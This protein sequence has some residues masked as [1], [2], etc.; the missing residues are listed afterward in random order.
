MRDSISNKVREYVLKRDEYTCRYCGNTKVPFHLDHVYPFSKGG[1]TTAQNLVTSCENC[2]YQKRNNVGIWPKPIGYFKQER[3][4]RFWLFWSSTILGT[5]L[6]ILSL[7]LLS[8]TN[9]QI[10][11]I[12]FI[13]YSICWIPLLIGLVKNGWYSTLELWRNINNES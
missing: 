4:R 2:N 9:T 3:F 7:L 13:V 1:E 6:T 10:R 11:D 12:G 5:L 8:E